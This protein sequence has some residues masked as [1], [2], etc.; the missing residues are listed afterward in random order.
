MAFPGFS[1][2]PCLT[3]KSHYN[4]RSLSNNRVLNT[5]TPEF[6]TLISLFPM[7]TFSTPEDIRKPYGFLMFP[8]GRERVH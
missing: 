3:K 2:I 7:Q 4:P 6:L 5:L 8:G 1:G